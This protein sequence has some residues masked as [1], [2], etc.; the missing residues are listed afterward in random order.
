MREDALVV[1]VTSKAVRLCK[2]DGPEHETRLVD[3]YESTHLTLGREALNCDLA[4]QIFWYCLYSPS[5][6]QL[7]SSDAEPSGSK[8]RSQSGC[9][10]GEALSGRA[11]NEL[12]PRQVL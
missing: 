2:N 3:R 4:K 9:G 5:T 1:G 8:V 7:R 12:A 11:M 6:K 10:D